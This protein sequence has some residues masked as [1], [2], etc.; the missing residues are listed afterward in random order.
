MPSLRVDERPVGRPHGCGFLMT[1]L[2]LPTGAGLMIFTR[3]WC[4]PHLLSSFALFVPSIIVRE[5]GTAQK[6][7]RRQRMAHS[8]ADGRPSRQCSKYRTRPRCMCSTSTRKVGCSRVTK[9]VFPPFRRC[10]EPQ[11]RLCR[12]VRP[13]PCTTQTLVKIIR[14]SMGERTIAGGSVACS[15]RAPGI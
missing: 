7:N 10:H 14:R 9:F 4:Y 3:S 5:T 8:E 1:V 6:H 2:F 12:P 11:Q 15:R 13:A